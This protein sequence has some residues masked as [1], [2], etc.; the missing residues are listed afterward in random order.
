MYEANNIVIDIN[1]LNIL[2][3]KRSINICV[4]SYYIINTDQVNLIYIDIKIRIKKGIKVDYC[5]I[6][7]KLYIVSIITNLNSIPFLNFYN[8]IYKIKILVIII[9]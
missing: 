3:T 8:Y 6:K 4:N 9:I 7:S 1:I 2:K 5:I